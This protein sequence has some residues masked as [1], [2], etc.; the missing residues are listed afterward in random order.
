MCFVDVLIACR[1]VQH[2]RLF[3]VITTCWVKRLL[4]RFGQNVLPA[5]SA[6]LNWFQVAEKWSKGIKFFFV[7]RLQY[8]QPSKYTHPLYMEV[9]RLSEML[10]RK[11]A[12]VCVSS[13]DCSFG[14]P[15][16]YF[17]NFFSYRWV[18]KHTTICVRLGGFSFG[19]F[20][21]YFYELRFVSLSLEA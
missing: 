2:K 12:R 9:R 10:G 14:T 6:R 3:R 1:L 11:H 16:I 7:G 20:C 18:S 21:T 5:Y 15:C 8:V 13:G 19:A 17:T 4:W